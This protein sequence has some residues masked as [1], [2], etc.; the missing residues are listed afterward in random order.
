MYSKYF[1]IK[2]MHFKLLSFIMLFI[3][4]F[5][6][7]DSKEDNNSHN[8]NPKYNYIIK[9]TVT[10]PFGC[11]FALVYTPDT[12]WV[13][14]AKFADSLVQGKGYE[15]AVGFFSDSTLDVWFDETYGMHS[16]GKLDIVASYLI[17]REDLYYN[18]QS[19]QLEGELD[20]FYF[21]LLNSETDEYI[22]LD[23]PYFIT[24]SKIDYLNTFFEKFETFREETEIS[25]YE[26]MAQIADGKV[27]S[28]VKLSQNI[29]IDTSKLR[30]MVN[31]ISPFFE[32]EVSRSSGGEQYNYKVWWEKHRFIL[33]KDT[34][35]LKAYFNVMESTEK[36]IKLDYELKNENGSQGVV[37]IK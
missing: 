26:I 9:D 7:S 29:D 4:L 14:M 12:S 33:E 8:I 6:C 35:D 23:N 15:S 11:F 34:L 20:T 13:D 3:I 17:P 1:I 28:L 27:D 2:I 10:N 18:S 31:L 37:T 22:R 5:S 32:G 25:K 30:D 19:E 16:T 36:F 21:H 24:K